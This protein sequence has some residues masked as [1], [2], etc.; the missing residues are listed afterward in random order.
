MTVSNVFN[1]QAKF[2]TAM[3]Q[4]VGTLNVEQANLYWDLV[5]EEFAECEESDNEVGSVDGLID[6]IVVCVG[7]L[8]SMGPYAEA[9]W[10]EVM[11]SNMAKLNPDGTVTRREDGKVLKPEGW[12]PPDI[13]GVIRTT[14]GRHPL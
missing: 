14:T 13:A 4:T 3:G 5:K 12:T 6:L 7:L 10:R 1:D 8:H 9:A 2:M 11:R